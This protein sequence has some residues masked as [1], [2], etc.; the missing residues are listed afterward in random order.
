[1][2][3]LQQARLKLAL[4]TDSLAST[5]DLNLFQ[6]IGVLQERFPEVHLSDLLAMAT[7]NGATALNRAQDFGSLS[8]G[9]KAALLFLPLA[10]GTSLWP[11][12][13]DS[14]LQGQMLWLT[15]KGKECLDGS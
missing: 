7:I 11:G 1:L 8:P 13:V 14:G 10:S 5:Q 4:G 3:G 2:N 12:V 6:E 9:K 15:H